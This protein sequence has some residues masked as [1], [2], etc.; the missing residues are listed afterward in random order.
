M[1]SISLS[2]SES[3][4]SDWELDEG[5]PQ[6]GD[7]FIQKY[8]QGRAALIEQ[9]KQSR[10]DAAF[11]SSLSPMAAEACAI[12]ARIRAE[13]RR[14]V[15]TNEYEDDLAKEGK[16]AE[17]SVFPGMMFSLARERME[18]TKLWQII[19]KMPKGALLHAHMDAMIDVE[20]LIEE[21]L[22]TDGMCMK[23]GQALQ[24]SE[25]RQEVAIAFQYA[26]SL[27]SSAASIWSKE[28]QNWQLVSMK[29]AAESFPQQGRAGF[30]AWLR[31]R[32]TITSQDSLEHHLGLHEIWQKFALCFPILNSLIFYE[33]I[34]RASIRYMLSEL[35]IDGIRW[36]D[37]RLAFHFEYRKSGCGDPEDGYEEM[38]RVFG[39][40]VKSFQN[41]DQGNGFWG[42][43]F[44]W[45][46]LRSFGKRN[47]I[48]SMKDCISAKQAHPDLIAGFD[49]VGQE[50]MGRPLADLTPELFWFRKRCVEERL[51]IPFFFHAG[52]CLGDG[53]ETDENL[54][55]AI[56]LGTRRI[57]HGFSLYK[58]PLL[59]EQV[60]AK[61][62]LIESCPISN[63]VLRLTSSV[64]SHPLPA[65][66]ARG[67]PCSLSNDDPA[68]LGHSK[69]GLTHDFWQALQGWENLG[70]EGIG[71]LAENSVRY[72]AF[73]PDQTT[74]EWVRDIKNGLSGH[75]IRASRMHEW[76]TEWNSFCEWIVMEF[77]ADYGSDV[78]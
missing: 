26:K 56:L 32:C 34:F 24:S 71:S 55:D 17:S 58:H 72:A 33:P 35:I 51:E 12:V 60:K 23:A 37:F 4:V 16:G 69:N 6:I 3:G 61:T 5:L 19:R 2:E 7:L 43:R 68:I 50:D 36:V 18:T 1:D 59:I 40:E 62:I 39:E 46:T 30:K 11:R 41:S 53:D 9:E 10:S 63:E 20:W 78:D 14:T 70:L 29:S 28:Y 22:G 8:L 15:W 54:F 64:L 42:C 21:A 31:D 49:L 48:G 73:A 13:E 76:R 52:E 66:L 65:L 47:I 74:Q 67:V 45:T 77:A 57:G 27:P 38:F 44:I 75:G 25:A